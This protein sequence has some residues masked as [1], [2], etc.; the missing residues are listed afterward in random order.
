MEK[1][2]RKD[3]VKRTVFEEERITQDDKHGYFV[4]RES[5]PNNTF[6]CEN[7]GDK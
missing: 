6:G 5:R 7:T 3:E 1:E 2:D 4:E